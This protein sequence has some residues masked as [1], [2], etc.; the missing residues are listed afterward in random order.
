MRDGALLAQALQDTGAAVT[1]STDSLEIS[2]TDVTARF[3]RDQDGV[4]SAHF[5]GDVDEARARELVGAIDSA[6]GRRVQSAVLDRLRERAPAAG[7]RL[8]S[9]T[10]EADSSVTLVLTVDRGA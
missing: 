10:V 4:W 3:D 2:W 5:G 7:L 1:S 9:E 8:D 6:Y